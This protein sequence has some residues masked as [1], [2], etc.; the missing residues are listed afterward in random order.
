MRR[1][2]GPRKPLLKP[3]MVCIVS[4][5]HALAGKK[6]VRPADI[7]GEP[8]IALEKDSTIRHRIDAYLGENGAQPRTVIE[9]GSFEIIKKF[10]AIGLGISIVPERAA[11]TGADG[12]KAIP[13]VKAP[14]FLELGA[15]YRKDR[16]L[17][18]SGKAFL[19][20]AEK[21]FVAV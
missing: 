16:F 8:M 14:P 13:F 6:F 19:E 21:Y 17:A 12:I 4:G 10:V 7:A 20:L 11:A 18:H 2:R 3:P 1:N 5:S 15:I 9:L